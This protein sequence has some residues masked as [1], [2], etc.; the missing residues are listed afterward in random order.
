MWSDTVTIYRKQA[1]RV[2]RI[3][4]DNCHVE[5]KVERISN[6]LGDGEQRSCSFTFAGDV[7]VHPGDR[8][9]PGIGPEARSWQQV[10]EESI[11]GL[12]E[13]G[14]I[15]PYFRQGKLHHT[16]AGNRISG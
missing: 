7:A 1:G 13:L 9:A 6:I 8:V 12:V 11:P 10:C 3:V 4:A 16:E 15:K 14:Y 2:E 5:V